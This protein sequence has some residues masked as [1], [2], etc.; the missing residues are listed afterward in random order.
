[1][2]SQIITCAPQARIVLQ[3]KVTGP[4]PLECI[5]GLEPP[6]SVSTI[7]FQDKKTR[8]NGKTKPKI[9]RQRLLFLVITPKFLNL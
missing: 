4:V 8:V 1:M 6:P 3:K 2:P 5:S 7:S 9:L